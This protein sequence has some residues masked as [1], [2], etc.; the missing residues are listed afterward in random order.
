MTLPPLCNETTILFVNRMTLPPFV[1]LSQSQGFL[2]SPNC[3]DSFFIRG[4]NRVLLQHSFFLFVVIFIIVTFGSK[5][6]SHGGLLVGAIRT[7]F[8]VVQSS[9]GIGIALG[10]FFLSFQVNMN[11]DHSK[12]PTNPLHSKN[13]LLSL[14]RTLPRDWLHFLSVSLTIGPTENQLPCWPVMHFILSWLTPNSFTKFL[15]CGR[16]RGPLS[17]A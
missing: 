4:H 6:A 10:E 8:M 12:E 1:Q 14:V 11:N 17:R 15:L 3:N 5:V 7:H 2:G 9:L 13:S 16:T